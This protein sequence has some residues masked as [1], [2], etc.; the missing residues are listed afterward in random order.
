M[1][2]VKEFPGQS[3]FEFS[4]Q[5]LLA[6]TQEAY[7]LDGYGGSVIW[8]LDSYRTEAGERIKHFSSEI[9]VPPAPTQQGAQKAIFL[10]NGLQTSLKKTTDKAILQPVLAWRNGG[11]S[12]SSWYV[13]GVR[14][15]PREVRVICNTKPI[16]VKSGDRL[17]GVM[18][19]EVDTYGFYYSCEFEN[20]PGSGLEVVSPFDLTLSLLALEAYGVTS[21]ESL[22]SK[23]L[24]F[25]NIKLTTTSS[26]KP[27]WEAKNHESEC[28]ISAKI[29]VENDGA[30]VTFSKG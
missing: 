29:S 22:P 7:K 21:C 16:P 10:F 17:A 11:W 23:D 1:K 3:L 30:D 18:T 27:S 4:Q 9:V 2:D 24:R 28:K 5:L 6:G 20:L 19:S 25:S 12:V 15:K 8:D 26:L 14:D 13:N